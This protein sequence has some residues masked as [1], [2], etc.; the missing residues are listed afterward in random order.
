M[1]SIDY[2]TYIKEL[3]HQVDTRIE[4]AID[5]RYE[6]ESDDPTNSLP[7]TEYQKG[8][9]AGRFEMLQFFSKLIPDTA[10]LVREL[11][12]N[13]DKPKEDTPGSDPGP[14]N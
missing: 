1:T 3:T 10:K 14:V 6:Y 9:I 5:R 8:L 11:Y 2:R 12:L 7:L 13:E 4:M